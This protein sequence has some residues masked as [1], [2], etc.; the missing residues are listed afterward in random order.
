VK[1]GESLGTIAARYE[2]SEE[3]IKNWNSKEI[4][5]NTI[6]AG[7]R[8]KIYSDNKSKGSVASSSKNVKNLPKYYTIRKGDTLSSIASKFGV[9]INTIKNKNKNL[10]ESRLSIGQKIRLQ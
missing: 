7:T 9:S 4:S 5:G 3:Q 10:K 2:V 1:K 6:F 8:L